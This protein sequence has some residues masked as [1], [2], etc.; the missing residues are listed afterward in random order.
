MA[1]PMKKIPKSSEL[2][3]LLG[4]ILVALGVAVCKKADLGVSMVAAMAFIVYEALSGYVGFLTVGM[5][6]YAIEGLFLIFLCIIVQRFNWRYLLA[7]VVAVIYGYTLDLWLLVLGTDPFP[8]LWLRWVMLI[9]GDAITAAGVACY[10]RTY[11]PLAVYELFVA[12]F[13]DRYRFSVNKTK[14]AFDSSALIISV[15]LAFTVFG[16]V[17]SFEWKSIA[18]TSFHSIGLGT[19]VTTF[20]NAPII[21]ASGRLLDKF[22][23]YTPLFP[24]LKILLERKSSRKVA[25]V[26]N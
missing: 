14:W 3:W 1:K 12:E 10:F 24:K 18:F 26:K 5:T 16:D 21:A 9:V 13:A 23:D 19:I 11:L 22:F 20:I 2:M 25:A 15:T 6:E 8:Y 17:S 4:I 7:F